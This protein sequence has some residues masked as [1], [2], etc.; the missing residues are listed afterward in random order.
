M[1]TNVKSYT[2]LGSRREAHL[3]ASLAEAFATDPLFSH[4]LPVER[5]R[6]PRLAWLIR[7]LIRYTLRS[8]SLIAD[9]GLTG[10]ALWLG[11]D[12]PFPDEAA[13]AFSG[14][15]LAPFVVGVP[16]LVRLSR[17]QEMMA[18]ERR[19]GPARHLYLFMLGVRPGEQGRGLG[20]A[21]LAPMLARADREGIPCLLE[22]N[23]ERNLP[24]YERHGFE[25]LSHGMIGGVC[26]YWAMRRN[27]KELE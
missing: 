9:D 21:L 4:A 25:V 27:P 18:R 17:A 10:A 20:S 2:E 26:P 24:L 8:G 23:K 3:A 16:G 5:T 7:R 14:M 1:S 15:I 22:T 19:R 11:P 6:L 13:M 12:R